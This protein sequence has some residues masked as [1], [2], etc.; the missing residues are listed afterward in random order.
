ML[1]AAVL[2][3]LAPSLTAQAPGQQSIVSGRVIASDVNT[4]L[5]GAVVAVEGAPTTTITDDAG[6][7]RL[8]GVTP[9]PNVLLVRYVGYA[10]AR[11]PILVGTGVT[12]VADIVMA[13]TALRLKNVVVTADAAGRARGELGTASVIDRD[14]IANQAA[15]S[16]SGVLELLPGVVLAPSGLGEVQQFTPRTAPTSEAASLVAG[17]PTPGDLASFGTVIVMDGVP[18]S[19]N[20]NLQTTG[21][22]GE[23]EFLLA[24]TSGGG[25]DLRRI[26]ASTID[27]VEVIRGIPSARYGD[28]TH[29]VVVV[30]SKAAEVQPA[31]TARYDPFTAEG[32]IVGGRLFR[33]GRQA[34]TASLDLALTRVSPGLR[35]ANARRFTA[36]LAHRAHHALRGSISP[37]ERDAGPD[38]AAHL[39][40][41]TKITGFQLR[42]DNPEDPEVLPGRA[43]WNHDAGMRLS[44]RVRLVLPSRRALELTAS[45]DQLRQRSHAQSLLVR[46]AMPFTDRLTEGRSIGRYIGGEFLSQLRLEGDVSQLY[47]RL[48]GEQPLHTLGAD[49]RLRIGGELRREWNAGAGYQ[50]DIEFPPQVSFNG[51]QGFDRPRRFDDLPAVATTAVYVDDQLHGAIGPVTVALQAG[52]RMDALHRGGTWFSTTRDVALQPRLNLEIAPRPWVRFRTAVGQMSKTPSLGSLS[53]APQYFDVVN[54]NWYAPNP[55]ERLA[56]LTTF[57]RDPTNPALGYS[58]A[59]RGEAGVEL[60]VAGTVIGMT[61]FSDRTTGGVG[62]DP[63]PGFLIRDRYDLSDSTLG[64][65]QPPTIVEPPSRADTVPILVDRPGNVLTLVNRG[66]EVNAAFGEIPAI[67]TRLEVQAAWIS[68]RF[69]SAAVDFGRGFSEFQLDE[70]DTRSPYWD[71]KTQV[72]ERSLMTYRLIHHQP[73]LGFIVTAVIQHITHQE[74]RDIGGTDSLSF[75]GYITRTGELVEVPVAMRTAPEFADLR[76]ER[77]GITARTVTLPDWMMNVQVSKTLPLNGRLSLNAFNV[78]DRLGRPAPRRPGVVNRTFERLQFGIEVSMPLGPAQVR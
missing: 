26:P 67:R 63:Q 5:T 33:E 41:D 46:G 69:N 77:T 23:L 58:R 30:D 28:L 15:T 70:R 62:I 6:R 43:S 44:E 31:L 54:V 66:Y 50:F 73:E 61:A 64:T 48:E 36:L 38:T 39:T 60:A 13:A 12:N 21:P 34:A 8:V 16:L 2:V 74:V 72:G 52:L 56:V 4:P 65:G 17:G 7:F 20:A 42:D 45:F 76:V 32:T 3:G 37:A 75:A 68:S 1:A 29:G 24:T 35:D 27:R 49:H 40:F 11:V 53:P 22:R 47:T 71:G 14:A 55:A 78:L 25:I 57:I 59:T 9:G 18:L 51:V 10:P 19:N